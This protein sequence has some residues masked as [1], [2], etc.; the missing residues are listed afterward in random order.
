MRLLAWTAAAV[1]VRALQVDD[2]PPPGELRAARLDFSKDDP[3]PPTQQQF[4]DEARTSARSQLARAIT[5][6]D[7]EFHID[8]QGYRPLHLAAQQGEAGAGGGQRHGPQEEEQ[9]IAQDEQRGRQ[10]RRRWCRG[11]GP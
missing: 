10:E 3:L 6:K 1:C 4:L 5:Y 7:L 9:D 2:A 11:V 8:H